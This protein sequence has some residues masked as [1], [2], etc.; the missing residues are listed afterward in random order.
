MTVEDLREKLSKYD[1]NLTVKISTPDGPRDVYP[2]PLLTD[3]N[4][5]FDL[6]D[7]V[8]GQKFNLNQ[9]DQLDLIIA[10]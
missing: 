8:E 6:N 9:W 4:H 5:L 10:L 7:I 2:E 3:G 1:G